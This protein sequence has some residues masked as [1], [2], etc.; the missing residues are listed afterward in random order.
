MNNFHVSKIANYECKKHVLIIAN[1][2]P[3][4]KEKHEK[5]S[6]KKKEKSLKLRKIKIKYS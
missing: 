3:K 2:L 4:E 1:I 5:R 6:E